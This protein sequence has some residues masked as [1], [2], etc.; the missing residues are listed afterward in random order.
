[1]PLKFTADAGGDLTCTII[2]GRYRIID[3]GREGWHA[4][5]TAAGGG[6]IILRPLDGSTYH[7]RSRQ[8]ANRC[9]AHFLSLSAET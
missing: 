8:A 1:M 9:Q 7:G 2:Q 5:F 6:E 3:F 4:S